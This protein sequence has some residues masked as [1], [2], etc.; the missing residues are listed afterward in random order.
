MQC[1][2]ANHAGSGCEYEYG[3]DSRTPIAPST[4]AQI[5]IEGFL[6]AFKPARHLHHQLKT[7]G[8]APINGLFDSLTV[9]PF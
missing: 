6:T 1:V 9:T 5:P 8:K 4:P 3:G 7:I 2:I